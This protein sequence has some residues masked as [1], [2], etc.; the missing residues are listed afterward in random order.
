MLTIR[1]YPRR[2]PRHLNLWLQQLEPSLLNTCRPRNFCDTHHSDAS[3]D[4]LFG[5]IVVCDS[6]DAPPERAPL[7]N[8]TAESAI[9]C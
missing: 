5:A 8:L 2:P 9:D 7:R 6:P 3:L 4:V 1:V